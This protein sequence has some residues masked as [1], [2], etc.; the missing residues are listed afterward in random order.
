V[1]LFAMLKSDIHLRILVLQMGCKSFRKIDG[2]V[3]A[4][5]A[6]ERNG[7]A[8]EATAEILLHVTVDN[9]HYTAPELV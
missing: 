7:Q 3:L 6:P 9:H 5:R 8:V 1:P 4:A 2:P